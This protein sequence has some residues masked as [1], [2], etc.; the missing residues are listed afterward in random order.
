MYRPDL[1]LFLTPKHFESSIEIAGHSYRIELETPDLSDCPRSVWGDWGPMYT[2]ELDEPDCVHFG[3]RCEALSIAG[4]HPIASPTI[5][6]N[7]PVLWARRQR[8]PFYIG[9]EDSASGL[10]FAGYLDRQGRPAELEVQKLWPEAEIAA[11]LSGG[12]RMGDAWSPSPE[13]RR[14]S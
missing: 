8:T 11:V 3:Y 14:V 2:M 9:L 12:L 7:S 10:C 5:R 1:R 13:H 6:L 4:R